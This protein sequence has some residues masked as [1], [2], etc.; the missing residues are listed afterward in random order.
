M[1]R[2]V[3]IKGSLSSICQAADKVYTKLK[4]CHE[5]D[6]QSLK[7]DV[8]NKAGFSPLTSVSLF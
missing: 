6:M 2:V 8:S 3:T 4:V 1:D 5:A 7:F